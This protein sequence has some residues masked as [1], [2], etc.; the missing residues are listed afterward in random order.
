[1]T[2]KD[3]SEALRLLSELGAT[4]RLLD[5]ARIVGNV[6]DLLLLQL[7]VLGVPCDVHLVEVGAVLHDVGKIQHPQ[8]LSEPG[9]LHEQAGRALLLFHRVQPEVARFC[10]SHAAWNSPEVSLEERIVAL[11]DKLWKGKRD[12]DLELN[13]IDEVAGRLGVLRWDVFEHLDSAFEK[14]ASAGTERVEQ[15]RLYFK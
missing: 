1:L 5:H 12:A 15:S 10:T 11:A 9:S 2:L 6:A 8:E 13:V 3:R 14:I 7:Q 4:D